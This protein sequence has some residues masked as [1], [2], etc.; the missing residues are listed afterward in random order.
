MMVRV[1]GAHVGRDIILTCVRWYVAYPL[2]YRQGEEL[3][4]E[5]RGSVDHATIH[6]WVLRYSSPLE[7][8]FHCRKRP[9]WIS[10]EKICDRSAQGRASTLSTMLACI[11]IL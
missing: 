6:R 4:E 5:R 9:V 3:L 7:A 8:A 11:P 10:S 2:S 1:K